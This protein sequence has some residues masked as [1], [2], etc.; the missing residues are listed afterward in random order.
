M[1]IKKKIFLSRILSIFPNKIFRSSF[2]C[3]TGMK[4]LQELKLCIDISNLPSYLNY[5]S[6]NLENMLE[7]IKGY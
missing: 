1:K 4:P 5:T 3:N 6:P 7:S 2:I